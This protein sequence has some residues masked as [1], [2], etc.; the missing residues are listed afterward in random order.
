[1]R[2]KFRRRPLPRSKPRLRQRLCRPKAFIPMRVYP[3]R[4]GPRASRS[5]SARRSFMARLVGRRAQGVTVPAVLARR[6][7][8]SD[9]GTWLWGDGSLQSLTDIIKTGV[10]TPKQHCGQ[11]LRSAESLYRTTTSPRSRLMSGQSEIRRRARFSTCWPS[12]TSCQPRLGE[13]EPAFAKPPAHQARD[14]RRVGIGRVLQMKCPASMI[15][16]L[17]LG[18][19]SWRYSAFTGGTTGVSRR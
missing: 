4:Q 19:S 12:R 1:M 2:Q 5:R 8:R 7:A 18:S 16:S 13:P 17:L 9:A 14:Q 11:C 6:W 10:P 3:Y 15:S